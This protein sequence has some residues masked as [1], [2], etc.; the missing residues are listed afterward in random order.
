MHEDSCLIPEPE[1]YATIFCLNHHEKVQGVIL[2]TD[3]REWP[4]D[5]ATLTDHIRQIKR[6]GEKKESLNLLFFLHFYNHGE[7]RKYD[8]DGIKENG[9]L[10]TL[11]GRNE[12]ADQLG[13]ALVTRLLRQSFPST[14]LYDQHRLNKALVA[15]PAQRTYNC[16]SLPNERVEDH[17][18]SAQKFL[19]VVREWLGP[20]IPEGSTRLFISTDNHEQRIA[21]KCVKAR[22]MSESKSNTRNVEMVMDLLLRNYKAGGAVASDVRIITPYADQLRLYTREYERTAE[23]LQLTEQL[24]PEVTTSDSMRGHQ[25]PIIIYDMVVTC[26][27]SSHGCGI[28]CRRVPSQHCGNPCD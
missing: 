13:L 3:T 24:F 19:S 11:Y 7:A 20:K 1:L 28:R 26:G 23:H 18:A 9:E 10:S 6:Q 4:M 17:E 14:R 16:L 5:L 21:S 8:P 15:F 27:D 25:A 22:G 12:F 2:S